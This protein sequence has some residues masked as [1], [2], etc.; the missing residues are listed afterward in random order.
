MY[1]GKYFGRC[2]RS[3]IFFIVPQKQERLLSRHITKYGK[4]GWKYDTQQNI[5]HEQLWDVWKVVK[6]YL[7]SLIHIVTVNQ[8]E[9]SREM[10]HSWLLKSDMPTLSWLSLQ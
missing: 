8:K 9:E 4:D 2:G 7:E 6:N 3:A 5:F 1:S 10:D